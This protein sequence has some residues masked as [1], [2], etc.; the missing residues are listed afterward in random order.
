M[1][2]VNGKLGEYGHYDGIQPQWIVDVDNTARQNEKVAGFDFFLWDCRFEMYYF[3]RT[4]ELSNWT[5]ESK[6]VK[7]S[8]FCD[9]S[10]NGWSDMKLNIMPIAQFRDEFRKN[11]S[12]NKIV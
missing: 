9:F 8:L 2:G 10:V 1:T 11:I 3:Q 5:L 7:N 4:F 12:Y 6:N